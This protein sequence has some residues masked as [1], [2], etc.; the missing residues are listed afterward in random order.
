[1]ERTDR[2]FKVVFAGL[3]NVQRTTQQANHPLAHLGDPIN[4]GALS[5]NGEWHAAFALAA[6]PLKALGVE[7]SSVDLVGRILTLCNFYP[8]LIQQFCSRMWRSLLDKRAD[9]PPFQIS[10]ADL[11]EVY[12]NELRQDIVSRF[13]LTLQ[14]DPR[15]WHLAHVVALR[16]L[17]DASPNVDF[18]YS[19][20]ELR[21]MATEWWSEGFANNTLEEFRSLLDEMRDLGVLRE[22]SGRYNVRNANILLLLGTRSEVESEVI[23]GPRKI[24]E[25]KPR[26]FRARL[27]KRD[28]ILR[29]PLTLSE[30]ARLCD[31]ANGIAYIIG[32]SAL[33][34]ESVGASLSEVAD[35]GHAITVSSRTR[36]ASTFKAE[37]ANLVS[38]SRNSGDGLFFIWVPAALNWNET[39]ID[40]AREHCDRLRSERRYIRLIFE[41]GPEQIWNSNIRTAIHVNQTTDK[42]LTLKKWTSDF[43]APY[44]VELGVPASDEYLND[45]IDVTGGW[46]E[47]M[48]ELGKRFAQ[49]GD[50]RRALISLKEKPAFPKEAAAAQ[51]VGTSDNANSAIAT[52]KRFHQQ[53]NQGEPI[54]DSDMTI[55]AELLGMKPEEL[56]RI[57]DIAHQLSL[58]DRSQVGIVTWDRVFERMVLA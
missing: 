34:I 43:I 18:G 4:V 21:D 51:F 19:V 57:I 38:T 17:E 22:S 40:I 39:W 56:Q 29:R 8:G 42:I 26:S 7:F 36:D 52:L 45:V 33:G 2:H 6:E 23:A 27:K 13:K 25:Y 55:H 37:L 16:F 3:H 28:S 54:H 24:A 50:W 10:E 35:V 15:Y 41:V 14:L 49:I 20:I 47:L 12:Q 31:H 44:L 1:M 30:E 32:S 11:D 46:P 9:G 5:K 48:H 58:V 53:L